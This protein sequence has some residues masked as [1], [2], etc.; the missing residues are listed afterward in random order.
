MAQEVGFELTIC[1]PPLLGL[2]EHTAM[3]ILKLHLTP[4]VTTNESILKVKKKKLN[5]WNAL[6]G[7]EKA[8]KGPKIA[9]K[10]CSNSTINIFL[11]EGYNY[12]A[13]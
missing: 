9:E 13:R 8:V 12:S 11:K 1:G 7:G 4:Q 3:P 10:V 5:L 6:Q 2:Q